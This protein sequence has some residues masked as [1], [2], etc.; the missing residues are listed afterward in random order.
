MAHKKRSPELVALAVKLYEELRSTQKVARRLRLGASTTH[1]LLKG[2]GVVMPARHDAE[3]QERKKVLKGDVA[4]QAA[5]DYAAGMSRKTMEK[6][7]G[8][9]WWAIRTAAKDSGVELRNRGGRWRQFSEED[10]AEIIRLY[11]EEKWSQDH[12]AAKFKSSQ[13]MIGRFLRDSGIT[14]RGGKSKRGALHGSWEGGRTRLHGYVAVQVSQDDPLR[15]MAHH[16]GYVLEHRLVMARA[17][18]RPLADY[19]TVHHIDGDKSNNAPSNLQLRFGR[20]GNGT[21]LRCR[22]CGSRDIEAIELEQP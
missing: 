21:V 16:T 4:K 11:V 8:V 12:L 1:R 17:L 5:A 2:A 19:E 15:C 9:G 20:H 18:G 7:Y 22:K 10:K 13:P 14:A 6:K 3:I